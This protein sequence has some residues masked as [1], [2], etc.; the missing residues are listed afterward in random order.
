MIETIE[1]T[2]YNFSTYIQAMEKLEMANREKDRCGAMRGQEHGACCTE[3]YKEAIS[4]LEVYI[5]GDID[6]LSSDVLAD[7]Q[8]SCNR[9]SVPTWRLGTDTKVNILANRTKIT[10]IS[11]ISNFFVPTE[12]KGVCKAYAQIYGFN[13]AWEKSLREKGCIEC[14]CFIEGLSAHGANFISK[15]VPIHTLSDF[16]ASEIV[17]QNWITGIIG[18]VGVIVGALV[19]YYFSKLLSKQKRERNQ[20]IQISKLIISPFINQLDKQLY[21]LKERRYDY[22]IDS[23]KLHNITKIT[24]EGDL[25]NIFHE[26]LCKNEVIRKGIDKH[27]DLIENLRLKL[28]KVTSIIK[29]NGFLEKVEGLIR[30]WNELTR[31]TKSYSEHDKYMLLNYV[32]NNRKNLYTDNPSWNDFWVKNRLE[33]LESREQ[34]DVKAVL[35]ELEEITINLIK[36]SEELTEELKKRIEEFRKKYKLLVREI[37]E[38]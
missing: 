12:S 37:S 9:Q 1:N 23:S 10:K 29:E 2:D 19:K 3:Y 24:I 35:N 34:K 30:E 22:T 4:L 32:I 18:F 8:V 33:L 13:R 27:N 36:I 28:E 31:Q 6:N 16:Y 14:Y 11:F 38:S 20:I 21:F 25:S 15:E 5:H 26:F 7:I 17:E